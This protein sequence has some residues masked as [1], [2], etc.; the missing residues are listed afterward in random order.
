MIRDIENI[1]ALDNTPRKPNP[2]SYHND[3][4]FLGWASI[5]RGNES[6]D[7]WSK[8]DYLPVCFISSDMDTIRVI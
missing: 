3:F 4:V 7:D 2:K 8:T 6:A 1:Y 5:I